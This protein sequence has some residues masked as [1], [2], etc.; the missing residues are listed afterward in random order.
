MFLFLWTSCSQA[1]SPSWQCTCA[2]TSLGMRGCPCPPPPPPKTQQKRLWSVRGTLGSALSG[3]SAPGQGTSS[4]SPLHH[5]IFNSQGQGAALI[6]SDDGGMSWTSG[7][8]P[9]SIP[10]ASV[11]RTPHTLKVKELWRAFLAGTGGEWLAPVRIPVLRAVRNFKSH[12]LH[13]HFRA[14]STFQD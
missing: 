7:H 9:S 11:K 4:F 8:H 3:R 14:L 5:Q 10:D 6:S 12:W 1:E 13:W 2:W